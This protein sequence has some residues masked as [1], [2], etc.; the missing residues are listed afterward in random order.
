[1]M[2]IADENNEDLNVDD[3]D[4]M[5]T[6]KKKRKKRIIMKFCIRMTIAM[7]RIVMTTRLMTDS[8][9]ENDHGDNNSRV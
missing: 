4:E 1:M 2:K 7:L 9:E 8:A 5:R 6:M 3:E